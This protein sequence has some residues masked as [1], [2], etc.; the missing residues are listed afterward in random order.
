[1]PD[2][3]KLAERHATPRPRPMPA[4]R[5]HPAPPPIVHGRLAPGSPLVVTSIAA[6]CRVRLAPAAPTDDELRR[7]ADPDPRDVATVDGLRGWWWTRTAGT[8]PVGDVARLDFGG[9][10]GAQWT[11]LRLDAADRPGRASWTCMAQH[12]APPN[13]ARPDEWLGTRHLF[14]VEAAGPNAC[15]LHFCHAGLTPAVDCYALC[16][17]GWDTHLA[18]L[19][20]YAE[21]GRGT[22]AGG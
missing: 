6:R 16:E 21:S 7:W 11:V 8:G 2:R 4:R 9:P 15:T 20:A 13:F 12:M 18:S 3:A 17:R 10:R 1:M 22:P 19:V 14:A 5:L